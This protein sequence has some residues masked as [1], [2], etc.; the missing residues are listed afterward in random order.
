VKLAVPWNV[1]V[2]TKFYHFCEARPLRV[3]GQPITVSTLGGIVRCAN[4]DTPTLVAG[5]ALRLRRTGETATIEVRTDSAGRFQFRRLAPGEYRLEVI[6][7][8]A[9]HLVEYQG[10][11]ATIRVEA[12]GA[13]TTAFEIERVADPR[14]P[15]LAEVTAAAVP[16]YPEAARSAA[17]EGT[18]VLRLSL[19]ADSLVDAKIL[20]GNSILAQSA[21]DN[22][23]TW[24][25]RNAVDLF[26]VTFRFWLQSSSCKTPRNPY[27]MM[28]FPQM[29]EVTDRPEAHCGR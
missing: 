17:I 13:S 5:A 12:N 4:C 6:G 21:I 26:D 7:D 29:V 15:P 11:L 25:F 16:T 10:V 3:L 8:E 22:V 19:R 9:S 20:A 14:L 28:Q 2:E 23:R 24:K 18:V 1:D 27:A